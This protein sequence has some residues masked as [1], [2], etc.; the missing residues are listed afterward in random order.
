LEVVITGHK[1]GRGPSKDHSTKVWSQLAQWFL[2]RRFLCELNQNLLKWFLG[3]P[4]P[5]LCPGISE[6]RPKWPP[7]PNLI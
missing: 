7:Q 2:R 4:F 1:F 3:G 6:H 5:K